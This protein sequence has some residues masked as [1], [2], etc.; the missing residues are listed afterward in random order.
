[1]SETKTQLQRND[2]FKVE[3]EFKSTGGTSNSRKRPRI[4]CIPS[5]PCKRMVCS[6]CVRRR[7]EYFINSGT[8]FSKRNHLESHV[9]VSWP[10][11]QD[12][13][14][15]LVLV[16]RMPELSKALSSAPVGPYIR[17]LGVGAEHCPHV[18]FLVRCDSSLLIK[19]T[20]DGWDNWKCNLH[21]DSV[22]D[23]EG[24]LGYFYDQ[25]FL[26]A[27]NNPARAKR[28]RILSASRGMLCGFPKLKT[29]ILS[30]GGTKE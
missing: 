3:T 15:W 27:Y 12:E 16:Q 11:Q 7:R 22:Y 2:H 13:D 6:V 25:N 9:V 5:W 17:T 24:L 28:I 26:P 4:R 29:T 10:L 21:I 19:K 8:Q 1:M 23:V 20:I 14:P 18:H 30:C